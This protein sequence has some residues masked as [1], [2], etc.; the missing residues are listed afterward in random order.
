MRV[1]IPHQQC[2]RVDAVVNNAGI[3]S[4]SAIAGGKVEK[5]DRIIAINLRGMYLM[6]WQAAKHLERGGNGASLIWRLPAV[7][8]G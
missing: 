6:M 2:R 1:D 3:M 7:S 8:V 4:L 5:F